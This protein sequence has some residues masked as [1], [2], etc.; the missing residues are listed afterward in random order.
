[1]DLVTQMYL[2]FVQILLETSLSVAKDHKDLRS[3]LH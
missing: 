1:M 3:R 2:F